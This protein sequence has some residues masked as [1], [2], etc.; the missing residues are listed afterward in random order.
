MSVGCLESLGSYVVT[1]VGGDLHTARGRGWRVVPRLAGWLLI[2]LVQ[3]SRTEAQRCGNPCIG[4]QLVK[5][6]FA[7]ASNPYSVL[8]ERA[9]SQANECRCRVVSHS[10]GR[11]AGISPASTDPRHETAVP[12]IPWADHRTC[13]I[14]DTNRDGI[15]DFN[16]DLLFQSLLDLG[17]WNLTCEC[18]QIDPAWCVANS[19]ASC[20]VACNQDYAVAISPV[21][22]QIT[23]FNNLPT[24]TI[25]HSGLVNSR[26]TVSFSTNAEDPIDHPG[27]PLAVYQWSILSRPSSSSGAGLMRADTASPTIAFGGRRDIGNWVFRLQVVDREGEMVTLTPD[28]PVTIVNT[29]PHLEVSN[30]GRVRINDAIALTATATDVDGPEPVTI[31]WE[32]QG[33]GRPRSAPS[34]GG[35]LT[36]IPTSG[37]RDV[38]TWHFRIRAEDVDRGRTEETRTVEVFNVP[39]RHDVRGGGTIRVGAPISLSTAVTT[40]DDGGTLSY[41]WDVVQRPRLGPAALGRIGTDSP[42]LTLPTDETWAGTWGFRLHVTDDEDAVVDSP[43]V[44]VLVDADPIARISGRET[45][46]I[47]NFPLELS[48]AGSSDPDSAC[49]TALST[50]YEVATGFTPRETTP[51][52]IVSHQ[53]F[54]DD[55]PPELR[56]RYHPGPVDEVFHVPARRP[57]VSFEARQLPPGR[58]RFR[59]VVQD[60]ETNRAEARHE[61][62][63]VEPNLPPIPQTSGPLRY[64]VDPVAGITADVVVE[65]GDSFDLDNIL[66]E[67]LGPGV[68][69]RNYHW[70]AR[71]LSDACGLS[72]TADGRDARTFTPLHRGDP[73]GVACLGRW[74][75]RLTVTDDDPTPAS[76]S[77]DWV[78]VLG[79]CAGAICVDWPT[80]GHPAT[81]N[82]WENRDVAIYYWIDYVLHS[83]SAVGATRIEILPHGSTTAAYVGYDAGPGS[84][85]PGTL[86]SFNW[87]GRTNGRRLDAGGDYDLRLTLLDRYGAPVGS[88]TLQPNAIRM[89]TVEVTVTPESDLYIRHHAL[90][91]GSV[92][93]HFG[94]RIDGATSVDAVRWVIRNALGSRVRSVE[95]GTAGGAIAWD[96]RD[97]GGRVQPPG[98]YSL[99]VEAYRGGH[100]LAAS[101]GYTFHLY[102]VGA[103]A[104]S[105]L[106]PPPGGLPILVNDD[107]D[108]HDGVGD[109]H[110]SAPGENDLVAVEITVVPPLAGSLT[111]S[112]IPAGG[113]T[114][115]YRLWGDAGKTGP[116]RAQ[117]LTVLL[118]AGARPTLLFVEAITSGRVELSPQ[119]TVG[120]TVLQ[121]DPLALNLIGLRLLSGADAPI[122]A[123]KVGLWT[124]GYNEVDLVLDGS[125]PLN[126][127]ARDPARFYVR[128]DDAA[129][130]TSASRDDARVRLGTPDAMGSATFRD[131]MTDQTL[132]ETAGHSGQ[133]VSLTQLLT[134]N[135]DDGTGIIRNSDD[136]FEVMGPT[137]HPVADNAPNDRTHSAGIESAVRVQYL[138]SGWP[139]PLTVEI[140]VCTRHPDERRRVQLRV[141]VYNEPF[142]DVGC[143]GCAPDAPG[144]PTFS[145]V[146]RNRNGVHDLGEPSEPYADLSNTPPGLAIFRRGDD[147]MTRNAR[148]GVVTDDYVDREFRKANL[149][150]APSCLHIERLGPILREDAPRDAAGNDILVNGTVDYLDTRPD[151]LDLIF[152]SYTASRGVI[153]TFFAVPLTDFHWPGVVVAGAVTQAPFS[154]RS[155]DQVFIV[156]SGF[157]VGREDHPRRTLAHELGHALTNTDDALSR[158]DATS[159]TYVFYPQNYRRFRDMGLP[160]GEAYDTNVNINRRYPPFVDVQVHTPYTAPTLPGNYLLHAY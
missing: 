148:G 3:A 69:I 26:S 111:V 94:Y 30:P 20:G 135:D 118:T 68:G 154:G 121:A 97:D 113:G 55:V 61:V 134:S 110:Q 147:P 2:G 18:T 9:T 59:V 141:H 84:S 143:T 6:T 146:D 153:E 108:D 139:T 93:A 76:A 15:L 104:V 129:A 50:C 155:P 157:P 123:A 151:E 99:A 10:P 116:E 28:H 106:V 81:V 77:I 21:V 105:G 82:S 96:G 25:S 33:P 63:V 78:F 54:V 47:A 79:N 11:R 88:P 27:S 112:G 31:T 95:S 67:T 107:D 17:L 87:N 40:D 80:T 19:L 90:E 124:D 12:F 83:E 159:P 72:A 92:T 122:F 119:L 132:T 37:A 120:G 49:P 70:T 142:Q 156:I 114:S 14:Y 46:S 73:I 100:R 149:A 44:Y 65:G 58:Y 91:D 103:R 75:A 23:V 125:D 32:V 35:V 101:A 8:G 51:P 45:L 36:P 22:F 43:P 138:P 64:V 62:R 86:L 130:D 57:V 127:V 34:T 140:P 41:R 60:G 115:P 71:A 102:R 66:V 117:P 89:E 24:G 38:G 53:W 109:L 126:F 5:S 4:T 16:F 7:S 150:W 136:A 137:L 133:F 85:L 13:A 144:R 145:F 160:M 56:R 152:G 48:A 29:E 1:L 39:P 98:T 42:T 131:V 52:G 74:T 158:E 128:V